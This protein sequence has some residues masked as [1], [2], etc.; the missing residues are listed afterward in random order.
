[1]LDEKHLKPTRNALKD[2]EKRYGLKTETALYALTE[3]GWRNYIPFRGDSGC[4]LFYDETG[5]LLYV[6]KARNL[7]ARIG[8]YFTSPPF[9]PTAGHVWSA[10]PRHALVIKVEKTWEAPSLEEYLIDRLQPSDN[11]RGKN[12]Q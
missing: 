11:T 3:E 9:A 6:G 4:Y 8:H 2:Y 1:M 5:R 7:G 10:M 12:W